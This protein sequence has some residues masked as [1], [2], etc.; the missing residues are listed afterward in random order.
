MLSILQP[1][2]WVQKHAL[3]PQTCRGKRRQKQR[4]STAARSLARIRPKIGGQPRRGVR[5]I[6][7]GFW[8]NATQSLTQIRISQRNFIQCTG[9]CVNIE[10]N[11]INTQTSQLHSPLIRFNVVSDWLTVVYTTLL[12]CQKSHKSHSTLTSIMTHN[13]EQSQGLVVIYWVNIKLRCRHPALS[14]F[15]RWPDNWIIT[16]SNWVN[17][18]F[19]SS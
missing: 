11:T 14:R 18:Q 15:A 10:W 19:K 3:A 1:N 13:C 5:F 6:F 9:R 7:S 17:C 8:L 2:N 16:G 4:E 12:Y